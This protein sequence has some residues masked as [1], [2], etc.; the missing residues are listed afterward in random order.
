MKTYITP[1]IFALGIILL[2]SNCADS[3]RS[4]QKKS[5]LLNKQHQKITKLLDKVAQDYID[6]AKQTNTDQAINDLLIASE[7]FF[8]QQEFK[9]ALWLA[10][11]ISKLTSNNVDLYRLTLV[12]AQ[13]LFALNQP[14]LAFEQ[15]SK[16]AHFA[17]LGKVKLSYQYYFYLAQIQQTRQL[18]VEKLNAKL[19]AFA[20]ND[21]ASIEEIKLIWQQFSS[22]TQWQLA[23]LASAKPPYSKGWLALIHYAN[24]YGD[25]V[26]QFHRYLINWQRQYPNHPANA[27]IDD[28]QQNLTI[29]PVSVISH[30][31]IILP[32]SGKQQAAGTAAQQGILA[33]YNNNS[34][35]QLHF[36]DATKLDWSTLNQKLA[37]L[38]IDQVIG[39]LL[40]NN[41]NSYL[42]NN[43]SSISTLL[44]NLP[45]TI[46]LSAEQFAISMRPEDEAIQAA[47]TLSR[48]AYQ[49]PMV[50]SH[51]DPVSKRIALSFAQQWQKNTGKTPELFYFSE[52]KNMQKSLQASLDV[53]QSLVRIKELKRRMKQTLK[54]E[55]RNRRD[56]D[57]IYVIG[58]AKQT[59]LLK[60]YIDVNISPFADIIPV[61]ASSRS[62]SAK[63]DRQGTRDLSGLTFTEI[64]WLLA[65][66]Q[67]NKPLVALNNQLWPQRSDS[68]QSIFALGFDSLTLIKKLPLMRQASYIRY[69]GQ[70]G[71]LKLNDNNILTR[72]LLWGKYRRNK[73]QAIVMD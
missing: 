41:V 27:I 63:V 48:R 2:L 7:Q 30:I 4:A 36:I 68:L 15:M 43:T 8:K 33:A 71:V 19:H 22:L 72:S 21:Q 66:K 29:L 55:S 70:I 18:N 13:S 34:A 35:Q 50:I 24:K 58:N 69:F 23:K 17:M 20:L 59:R 46:Q 44:L 57:M 67:Q 3:S 14:Q 64:P 6:H 60:P 38:N 73:V 28:I 37:D 61:F 9:R 16:A 62:H 65:S 12:K 53:S 45:E 54:T 42:A 25:K 11:Q 56:I 32:L 31:A 1:I 26:N 52:G 49:K 39:P 40:K 5:T 51:N 10:N 47:E